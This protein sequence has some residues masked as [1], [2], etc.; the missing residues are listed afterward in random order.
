MTLGMIKYHLLVLWREPLNMFFG[1]ALPFIML[2]AFATMWDEAY[3]AMN[4]EF[5]FAAWLLIAA[6]VLCFTDAALSH[7]Y[8]RQTKFLRRLR[9]TS[10]T[11][12][13]YILTGMIS[14]ICVLVVMAAALLA[15]MAVGYD[16]NLLEATTGESRNLLLFVALLLWAFIMFYVIAMTFVNIA[17]NP[18]R[19]E[20][21]VYM[22]FFGM[23][24][25]GF[26]IPLVVFENVS[27]TLGNILSYLPHLSAIN[28]L[29]NA[30]RGAD[31]F[32]GSGIN[33]FI[34]MIAYTVVFGLLSLKFFRFE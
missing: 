32:Y 8:A 5:N 24:L 25:V 10:V 31:I 14:R 16:K 27:E 17:K 22:S 18:K 15:V 28:V 34:A 21:V 20:G 19:A 4:L 6:M 23:L 3:V 9:M 2:F 1:F 13:N 7:T 33:Y 12:Q 26:W 11:P 30:W 29:T